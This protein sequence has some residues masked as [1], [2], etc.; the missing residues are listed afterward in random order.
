MGKFYDRGYTREQ[1]AMLDYLKP[2]CYVETKADSA[3]DIQGGTVSKV[4]R[5]MYK[6]PV[7]VQVTREKGAGDR[8]KYDYIAINRITFFEPYD[9]Y[10]DPMYD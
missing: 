6:V 5:D 1:V 4:I 2:G 9:E 8:N 3:G 10:G 7:C